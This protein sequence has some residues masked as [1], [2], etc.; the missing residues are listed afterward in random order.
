M[1][2]NDTKSPAQ[3]LLP[4]ALW[5]NAGDAGENA[6]NAQ[7]GVFPIYQEAD[8]KSS[9][10]PG[11]DQSGRRAA[12]NSLTNRALPTRRMAPMM[13]YGTAR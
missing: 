6:K 5:T 13:A 11:T 12:A 9:S 8:S 7:R 10:D 3:Y 4:L 1:W 2:T